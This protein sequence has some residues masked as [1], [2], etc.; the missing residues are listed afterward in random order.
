MD[1]MN[2][3]YVIMKY[4]D[5]LLEKFNIYIIYNKLNSRKSILLTNIKK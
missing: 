4:S 2:L 1:K 5:K 3:S